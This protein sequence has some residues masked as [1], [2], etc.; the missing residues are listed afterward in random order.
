MHGTA[1][2]I[3]NNG[4]LILGNSGSGKTTLA[5]KLLESEEEMQFLSND[6]VFIYSDNNQTMEYFPIPIVYAM[7][8]VKNCDAL[9][10]YF[11]RTRI[12]EARNRNKYEKSLDNTKSR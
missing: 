7:G 12:L 2:N 5:T 10:N 4:I 6:R 9:N 11:K 3:D 8:T 1:L